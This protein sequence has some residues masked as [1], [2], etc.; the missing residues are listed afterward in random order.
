MLKSAKGDNSVKYLQNFAIY[1]LGTICEPN[2]MILAQAVLQIFFTRCRRFT[3]EKS[4]KGRKRGITLQRQ[5][6]RK[7]KTIRVRL[8]FM[9]IPYTCIKFQ[10]PICNRSWPYA[11]RNGQTDRP[12]PICPLNFLEVGGIKKLW[13]DGMHL[14]CLSRTGCQSTQ[15]STIW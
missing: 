1:T 12:K 9:L 6:R 3:M 10:D 13:N 2:I 8:F 15:N 7:R 14:C 5:F 4:K 11:K